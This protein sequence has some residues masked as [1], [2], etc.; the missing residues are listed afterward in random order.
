MLA[1]DAFQL[2]P[3]VKD[4]AALKAGLGVSLLEK[5]IDRDRNVHL[6][7]TQYRMH[8]DIWRSPTASFTAAT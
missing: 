3:T 4:P 5:A 7:D 6:L 8:A 2:P 1:G